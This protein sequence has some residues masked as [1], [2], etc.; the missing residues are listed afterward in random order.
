VGSRPRPV[1]V[2]VYSE[3]L[4]VAVESN[5]PLP[6]QTIGECVSAA[7][8][9]RARLAGGATGR[10]AADRIGDELAYDVAL[11]RLC[12]RLAI[13]HDFLGDGPP[14]DTRRDA[15]SR[16]AARLPSIAAFLDG[17]A[18]QGEVATS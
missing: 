9:Y 6:G 15:E 8:A 13:P 7:I 12:Q 4:R 5:D 1:A 18:I 2:S 16:L 17:S 14:D 10:R 11:V 3:L